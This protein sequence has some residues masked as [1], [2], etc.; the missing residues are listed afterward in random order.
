MFLYLFYTR[1]K[2]ASAIGLTIAVHKDP[3]TRASAVVLHSISFPFLP[4][5]PQTWETNPTLGPLLAPAPS[6]TY[7]GPIAPPYHISLP[8]HHWHRHQVRRHPVS[9]ASAAAPVGQMG[10]ADPI[11]FSI[12]SSGGDVL[13]DH[14]YCFLWLLMRML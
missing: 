8:I 12:D 1:G 13:P 9:P 5:S 14:K 3:V 4:S 2:G 10:Q 6:P 7:S 11:F